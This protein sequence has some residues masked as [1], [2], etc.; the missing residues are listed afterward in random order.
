[1]PGKTSMVVIMNAN[2]CK[3]GVKGTIALY[4]DSQIV[5]RIVCVRNY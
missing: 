1:M 4:Q 3:T 5:G 2:P